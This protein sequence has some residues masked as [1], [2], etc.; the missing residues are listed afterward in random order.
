[1]FS[2][3]RTCE[4]L[5][6][7][8]VS[9]PHLGTED[10]FKFLHQSALGCEHLVASAEAAAEYIRREAECALADAPAAIERLDGDF[11]RVPLSFLREGLS[12][13]TLARLFF[14]SASMA[15]EGE[16]ALA[17]RLSVAR[18]MVAE[19]ILPIG[20]AEF[21]EKLSAWRS[22]GY[23]AVHH[24][25]AFRSA[26]RPA[27]RVI[28]NELAR[29]L[30]L[31]ARIDTALAKGRVI[32]AIE[33]GSA[34]GKT[35]LAAQLREI[36]DCTVLHMDDFFLRPEQ[37]TPERFAEIGGNVDRERFLAEVLLP[38]F[39][40][41]DFLYRRFDCATQSLLRGVPVTPSRLTVVEGAYSMHPEL[42]AYYTLSVFLENSPEEQRARI[43]RRNTP[44]H[45]V[46]F[47]NEWIPLEHRY[48]EGM[49]VRERCTLVMASDGGLI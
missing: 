33:G 49:R 29:L 35:T 16:E 27:Y 36:Y 38:L 41:E 9:H 39:R 24:S 11:C 21:D 4:R 25:D 7:H 19:G 47:F 23:P 34:S 22:R 37:R 17:E 2:A 42:A 26:Y 44:E 1:M 40:G 28:A 5:L 45:A 3:E 6:A 43:L 12:P 46:R 31:L 15:G 8:L 18:T 20:L 10:I 14:L 48:F 13:D 30:P 32:L